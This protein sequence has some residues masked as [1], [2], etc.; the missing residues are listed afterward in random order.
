EQA[1]VVGEPEA[2]GS[3]E[4]RGGLEPAGQ[5]IRLRPELHRLALL[6]RAPGAL[7]RTEL[8]GLVVVTRVERARERRRR[9]GTELVCALESPG[10]RGSVLRGQRRRGRDPHYR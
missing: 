6:G 10:L 4:L 7:R 8:L 1:C 3:G 9:R 5:E 2:A